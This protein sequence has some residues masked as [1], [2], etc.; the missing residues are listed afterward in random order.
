MT[1]ATGQDKLGSRTSKALAKF[2]SLFVNPLPLHQGLLHNL[3][4]VTRILVFLSFCFCHCW[5]TGR[6]DLGVAGTFILE[7][8]RV[9]GRASQPSAGPV[10]AGTLLHLHRAREDIESPSNIVM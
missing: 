4:A 5:K 10:S 1:F 9:E 8:I 6:L 7:Q 3:E 2:L